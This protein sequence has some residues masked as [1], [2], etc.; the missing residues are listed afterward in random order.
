MN[1]MVKS[2][3]FWGRLCIEWIGLSAGAS[4]L[5]V[6]FMGAGSR[7]F[8]GNKSESLVDLIQLYPYYLLIIGGFFAVIMGIT[9]FQVYFSVVLSMNAT[10]KSFARGICSCMGG[11]VVGMLLIS[12]VIWR[13]VPGEISSSGRKLTALF[14]G[15]LFIIVAISLLLG[16]VA[17]RWGK[18]GMIIVGI[19]CALT[20]AGA[21]MTVALS[22]N[23]ITDFFIA[24]ADGNF[25]LLAIAGIILYLAVSIFVQKATQKLEVRV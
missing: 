7:D 6:L 13:M 4:F 21:G 5:W 19:I 9:Y 23:G 2:I 11:M 3:K 18:I 16:V 22:N 12:A 20:G 17:I 14:A 24:V 1:R 10:R 15:A 8:F 25:K